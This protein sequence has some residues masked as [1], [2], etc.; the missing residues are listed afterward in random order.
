MPAGQIPHIDSIDA[1]GAPYDVWFLDIWGVLHN[2]VKPFDG[3]VAACRAFRARGGSVI[4]VSNSPRPRAGVARQLQQIGVPDDAFDAILTS[5]DVSR[6]LIAAYAGAPVFHLGP[7]R[8][9]ALYDGTGVRLGA[10]K[11]ATAVICTGLFNDETE[12]P[13]TYRALLTDFANRGLPMVCVN[14][15]VTVERGQRIIYCAGALAEAYAAMGANVRYA[16]KPHAPIYE[17]AFRMASALKAE[18]VTPRRVLAIGD[19]VKTDIGGALSAGV[20]AVYVASPVSMARGETLEQAAA[21]LFPDPANRPLA[22]MRAL[23]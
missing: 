6:G 1:V 22:V 12:T 9:L 15:D 5:G 13:D 17:E 2:G 14:P 8:D 18:P 10:A 16:G 19:G 7:D 4:L 3:A 11:A 20:A 23:A 21:R